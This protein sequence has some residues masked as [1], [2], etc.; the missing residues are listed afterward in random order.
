MWTLLSHINK[1][2]K[3]RCSTGCLLS[4][5]HFIFIIHNNN[6]FRKQTKRR[7]TDIDGE[8]ADMGFHNSDKKCPMNKDK[9]RDHCE[10]HQFVSEHK[11]FSRERESHEVSEEEILKSQNFERKRDCCDSGLHTANS[12]E[13]EMMI[14]QWLNKQNQSR[15]TISE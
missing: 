15:R 5:I 2:T 14:K 9:Q 7:K 6:I 3:F 1:L 10:F 12:S 13:R 8:A 11:R 4:A